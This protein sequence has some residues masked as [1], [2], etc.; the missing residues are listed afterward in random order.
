MFNFIQ[1][2]QTKIRQPQQNRL[3]EQGSLIKADSKS[4]VTKADKQ[5]CEDDNWT[6][7]CQWSNSMTVAE[8]TRV[9]IQAMAGEERTQNS[10]PKLGRQTHHEATD[11]QLELHRQIVWAEEL[12]IGGKQYVS[13]L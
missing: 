6:D 1:I 2:R 11:I 9:G 5:V 3:I 7:I 13:K 8:A 12:Q 10:E 4:K